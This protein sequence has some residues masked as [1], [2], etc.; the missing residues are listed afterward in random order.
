MTPRRLFI[1]RCGRLQLSARQY[2]R[3][4][5]ISNRIIVGTNP[6]RRHCEYLRVVERN[7]YVLGDFEWTAWITW[8]GRLWQRAPR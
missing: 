5:E 7:P 8:G 2:E 6:I 3:I 4:T 1:S